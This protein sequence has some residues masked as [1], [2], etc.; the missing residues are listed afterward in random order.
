MVLEPAADRV[1]GGRLAEAEGV[2]EAHR[3]RFASEHLVQRPAG[4]VERE[5]ERGRLERPV[6]PAPHGVPARR[7]RPLVEPGQVVAQRL[8]RPLARERQHRPDRVERVV[9]VLE[10]GDVLA[11]A[12]GAT[13]AQAHQ[14]G[15]AREPVGELRG[16]PLD[17]VAL[18]HDR[19]RRQPAPRAHPA[20]PACGVKREILPGGGSVATAAA[21]S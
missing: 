2:H 16:A 21:R 3:R 10:R 17:L 9:L 15:H 12:L 18:D 4:L 5:V 20:P 7:H 8:E 11:E 13:A 6:A 14:R 1:E 19:E